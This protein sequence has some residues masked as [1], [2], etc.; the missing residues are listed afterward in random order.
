LSPFVER[1]RSWLFEPKAPSLS[2]FYER[3]GNWLC[4]PKVIEI[5]PEE[6]TLPAIVRTTATQV[7]LPS[8]TAPQPS[9][10]AFFASPAPEDLDVG[11][12]TVAITTEPLTV[13]DLTSA[14]ASVSGKPSATDKGGASRSGEMHRMLVLIAAVVFVLKAIL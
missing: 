14:S 13:V 9:I 2:S 4:E 7:E 11:A 10:T 6:G 3:T 8:A 12:E 5:F 1:T